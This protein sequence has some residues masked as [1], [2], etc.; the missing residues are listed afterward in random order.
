MIDLYF[1]P[2]SN[3]KKATIMLHEVG[4]PYRL[5]LVNFMKDENYRD[6]FL[7][8]NPNAKTPTIVDHDGPG[9]KPLTVFESGAILLYLA[10]KS[11]KLMPRDP[12]LRWTVTQWVFFQAASIGPM[13]GQHAHFFDYCP[14]EIPWAKDRYL[15]E[16]RRLY[17]VLDKRLAASPYLGGPDFT[18]AD[19][20]VMF[21]L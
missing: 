21:P 13:F 12:P 7:A 9:G 4:L 1:W 17:G 5:H 11:G 16:V 14:E 2:T 6:A 8:L 18:C 15:N 20:M 3:N 10:E 19:V